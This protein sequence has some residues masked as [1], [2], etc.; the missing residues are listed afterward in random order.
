MTN[1][2]NFF[3]HGQKAIKA[4]YGF[5]A[6]LAKSPNMRFRFKPVNLTVK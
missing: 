2:I 5:G 1:R 3:E 6:Y 4:M